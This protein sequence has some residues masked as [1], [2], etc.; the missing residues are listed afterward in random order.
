MGDEWQKTD[1]A[2]SIVLH[3]ASNLSRAN[4]LLGSVL[5]INMLQKPG[6]QIPK[7]HCPH[8]WHVSLRGL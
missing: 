2:R 4:S 1:V 5:V 8:S 3:V 6:T 7:E